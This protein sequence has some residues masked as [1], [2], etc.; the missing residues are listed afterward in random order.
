ML[1]IQCD[2]NFRSLV[3][4]SLLTGKKLQLSRKKPLF[5]EELLFLEFLDT[6]SKGTKAILNSNKTK[7]NFFPGKIP[8]LYY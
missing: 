6:V 2:S 1:K 5:P 3:T 4:F 7:L 8:Y